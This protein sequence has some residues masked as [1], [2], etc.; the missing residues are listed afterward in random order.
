M[1]ETPTLYNKRYKT[2]NLVNLAKEGMTFV[3]AR[4]HAICVPSRVSLLTGQNPMRHGVSGDIDPT[5][6]TRQTIEIP[7]G[8]AFQDTAN[9][10]PSLLRNK[11]YFTIHSGKFHVCHWCPDSISPRPEHSGF[12]VNIGGSHFGAPGS[13]NAID[14]FSRNDSTYFGKRQVPG[15]DKY[16]GSDLHLTDILTT[17]SLIQV[18]KSLDNKKPFFLYQAHFAVHTPIQPHD[19]FEEFY[20]K[21]DSISFQ[22][23]AYASMIEG[24]D[25]SLGTI[26]DSLKR[27][28]QTDNTLFIFYSDN[29]GRVLGRAQASLHGDWEYNHPLRSGKASLYEGGLKVPAIIK[30]PGKIKPNSKNSTPIV[31]EDIYATILKTTK[32][33]PSTEHIYDGKNLQTLFSGNASSNFKNREL[34]FYMPYRFDGR[35]FNGRKFANGGVQSSSTIIQNQWKLL[36][37]HER[38][39]FELYHLKLDPG[40]KNNLIKTHTKTATNLVQKLDY[41]MRSLDVIHPIRLPDRIPVPWPKDAW[42]KQFHPDTSYIFK[43]PSEGKA[44]KLYV[45]GEPSDQL[46][47]AIVFFFGGGWVGGTPAQFYPHAQEFKK[48]GFIA[49]SA[50]YRTRNSHRTKPHQCVEDGKS[51]I[52]WVRENA[53]ELGIDPERIIAAGGSAGGHVAASAGIIV[54]YDSKVENL[55]VSSIPNAMVLY[56]PVINTSSIGYGSRTI[57]QDSLLLSPH[58]LVADGCPP[59]LIF[60]GTGDKTVPYQNIKI[61]DSKMKE[62]GN[63][64]NV[65]SFNGEDHGFFNHISFRPKGNPGIFL[66]TMNE[67]VSFLKE[68]EF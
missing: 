10:L 65:V 8:R 14:N 51:A 46:K 2:P 61:F 67:A 15:L 47:P 63:V 52:R 45:F 37:F 38:E 32:A 41:Q 17:E 44:L 48:L 26:M 56:N 30:W 6:N 33:A 4:A 39:L 36:F 23:N 29:G 62:L 21:N 31:I 13:Y 18:K 11:G 68:I 3:N 5:I 50:D 19:P 16:H 60:H 34:F 66:Q 35:D 59:T 40:E 22:E 43:E 64:C 58:H 27:W 42:N 25:K 24:V 7:A 1:S 53:M 20:R 55:S 12:D 28:G 54:G 9:M 49:I 57:G